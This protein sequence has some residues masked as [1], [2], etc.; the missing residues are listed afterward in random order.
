MKYRI[1]LS[2]LVFT[3]LRHIVRSYVDFI[4]IL[5]TLYT[6]LSGSCAINSTHCALVAY[7]PASGQDR[8]GNFIT[9]FSFISSITQLGP[10]FTQTVIG[11]SGLL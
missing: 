8:I 2:L 6:C 4:F 3:L 10:K 5:N 1:G 9:Q 7:S 11:L